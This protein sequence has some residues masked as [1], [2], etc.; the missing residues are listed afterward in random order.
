MFKLLV[1]VTLVTLSLSVEGRLPFHSVI[2]SVFRVDPFAKRNVE[3]PVP[4]N[5][6]LR[7]ITQRLDNF[8]PLNDIIWEQRFYQNDA[9]YQPGG[10][11]ILFLA[12]EWAIT[13]ERLTVGESLVADLASELNGNIV[14]LEHRFYGESRPTK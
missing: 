5:V 8:D 2:N 14:Y 12:G 10:P 6:V 1:L 3:T 13:P 11:I 4:S 7:S 9:Y